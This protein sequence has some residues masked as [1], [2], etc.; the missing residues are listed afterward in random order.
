MAEDAPNHVRVFNERDQLETIP[1]TWTREAAC[2]ESR[3]KALMES[4][5]SR[6]STTRLHVI[7]T[8]ITLDRLRVRL[9]LPTASN[10]RVWVGP[11]PRPRAVL[12]SLQQMGLPH[13]RQLFRAPAARSGRQPTR[14]ASAVTERRGNGNGASAW[15][16]RTRRRRAPASAATGS[17]CRQHPAPVPATQSNPSSRPK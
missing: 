10:D 13:R 17:G 14:I 12:L 2:V 16:Q 5:R 9:A 6:S 15:V 7:T 4:A 8:A 3:L 1:A 11:L